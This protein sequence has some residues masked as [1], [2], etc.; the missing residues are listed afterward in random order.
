M[1]KVVQGTDGHQCEITENSRT[2]CGLRMTYCCSAEVIKPEDLP[3]RLVRLGTGANGTASVSDNAL[4][5]QG[6]SQMDQLVLPLGGEPF[7]PAFL[8]QVFVS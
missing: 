3:S 7:P 1:V 5:S 2:R 6:T 8:L 4:E